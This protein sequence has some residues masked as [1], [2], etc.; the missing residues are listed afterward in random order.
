MFA[1]GVTDR[2]CERFAKTHHS[3]VIPQIIIQTRPGDANWIIRSFW[4]KLS[5]EDRKDQMAWLHLVPRAA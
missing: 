4:P 3:S 2:L 1:L 5:L